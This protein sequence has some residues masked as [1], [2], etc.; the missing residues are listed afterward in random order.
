MDENKLNSL[1]RIV[2]QVTDR[3]ID[4]MKKKNKQTNE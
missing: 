1:F 3:Q 2:R 4:T